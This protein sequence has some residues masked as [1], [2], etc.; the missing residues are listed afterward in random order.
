MT[1]TILCEH[2]DS[3]FQLLPLAPN[4]TAHCPRCGA[5]LARGSRL[6]LEHHLALAITALILFVLCNVLPVVRIEFE[7]L[8]NQSTLTDSVLSL[9]HGQV[10]PMAAVIAVAV[11]LAPL[12]QILLLIWVLGH[13]VAGQRAPGL[14]ICLRTLAHLRPWSM[15]EVC[16]LGVLVAIIKLSS[17]LEVHLGMGLWSLAMLTVLLLLLPSRD[18]PGLW[19]ELERIGRE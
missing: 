13:A 7:G 9:V 16:L 12:L 8:H 3:A 18:L 4:D 1:K 6:T 11:V 17:M 14:A 10:T 15:L 19:D 5:V 2:C